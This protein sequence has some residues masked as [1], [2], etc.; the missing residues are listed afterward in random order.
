MSPVAPLTSGPFAAPEPAATRRVTSSTG[1][2]LHVEEFG[3]AGGPTVVLAHGWT[4]NIAFW[5]PVARALAADGVR[6]V[7]YDQRGHGRSPATPGRYSTQA[8][9]DDLCAVLEAV[10]D[11]RQQAVVGGH[12]MG[13]MTIMAAAGRP[14]LARHAAAAFLCSTGARRLSAEARVLPVPG[15][16]GP[17]GL[18]HRLLLTSPAPLGPVSSVSRAML[19]YATMGPGSAPERIEAC[20]RIVHA[21]HRTVR[22]G[23]GKVLNELD[24]SAQVPR[25]TMPTAVLA[26]THD[27][28]T[29]L[30]HARELVAALPHCVGVHE[31]RGLG[32]MTPLEDPESVTDVLRGLV[33][34]HLKPSGADTTA[35]VKKESR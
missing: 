8:L 20:A 10:L 11:P 5:A 25:L 21:C 6:V 24:L 28:L 26:G 29:P 16:A 35:D 15:G 9:A 4:C 31:K 12:S 32:H 2:R 33:A 3:P 13:G 23:W 34:D 19:A 14:T 17:R 1:A 27:R 18:A 30:S 22:R 7:A